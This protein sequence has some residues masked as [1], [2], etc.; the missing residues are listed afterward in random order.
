MSEKKEKETIKYGFEKVQEELKDFTPQKTEDYF[1]GGIFL[2]LTQKNPILIEACK[3]DQEF[4]QQMLQSWKSWQRC[5]KYAYAKIKK[6]ITVNEL[7]MGRSTC[8][9]MEGDDEEVMRY[10]REYYALDDKEQVE[11]EMRLEKEKKQAEKNKKAVTPPAAGGNATSVPK[12]A[13]PK[14][15]SAAKHKKKAVMQGQMSFF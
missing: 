1:A 4:N 3:N 8:T 15:V 11:K 2:C 7:K 13:I 10:I 6:N 5:M 14:P 12:P 9:S